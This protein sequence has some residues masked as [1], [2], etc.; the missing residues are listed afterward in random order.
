VNDRIS[1]V[2][3][4]RLKVEY[5]VASFDVDLYLIQGMYNKEWA[6]ETAINTSRE[7]NPG[8]KNFKAEIRATSWDYDYVGEHYTR[9]G[10]WMRLVKVH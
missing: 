8:W 4:T 7:N 2:V 9:D 6:V 3:V 10:D 5:G 1:I